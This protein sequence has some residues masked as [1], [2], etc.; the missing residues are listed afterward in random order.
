MPIIKGKREVTLLLPRPICDT[1]KAY[2]AVTG[3][4]TTTIVIELLTEL[5][6]KEATRFKNLN[7]GENQKK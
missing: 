2:R 5:F 6:Q 4:D 1:L 3:K 7:I